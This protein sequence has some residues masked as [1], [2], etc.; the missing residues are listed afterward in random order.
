MD[1]TKEILETAIE[2]GKGFD[3]PSQ[4]NEIFNGCKYDYTDLLY[5]IDEMRHSLRDKASRGK[6]KGN[7]KVANIYGFNTLD[8]ILF[9]GLITKDFIFR[10]KL[11]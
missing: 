3:R 6:R 10:P 7:K 5:M 2:I 11:L 4:C 8:L 1:E 9:C